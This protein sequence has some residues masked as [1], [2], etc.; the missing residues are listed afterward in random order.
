MN[1]SFKPIEKID[2]PPVTAIYNYY[3]ENSTAT[4]HLA[5]VSEQEMETTL[6]LGHRLYK[7][8][9]ILSEGVIVGFCYLGQFRKKEAYDI[10]SEVTLYIKHDF[11]GKKIGGTV[12]AFMEQE[13][14]NLGLKNL[15]GVITSENTGSL[16]LFERN[17][18][19]K[20]GHLKNIGIKF[21]KALD[22]ISYQKEI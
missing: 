7:S 17:G 1:I 10:S 2:L 12:L 4:F 16:K 19:F 21:G 22:V 20:C 18:Y 14:K 6:L 9:V 8:F 3:V 15:V 11:T 13:A 5:P